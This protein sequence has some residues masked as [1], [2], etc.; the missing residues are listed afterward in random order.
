MDYTQDQFFALMD[1]IEEVGGRHLDGKCLPVKYKFT[2]DQIKPDFLGGCKKEALFEIPY[3]KSAKSVSQTNSIKVCAV[4]DD[5]GL[6]P[7]FIDQV[8]KAK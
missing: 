4:C 3:T 1:A 6:W 8:R 7:R 2:G 5:V